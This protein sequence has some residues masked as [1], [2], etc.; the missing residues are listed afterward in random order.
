MDRGILETVRK[1][2]KV[3]CDEEKLGLD[4]NVHGIPDIIPDIRHSLVQFKVQLSKGA[5]SRLRLTCANIGFPIYSAIDECQCLSIHGN[6]P[7]LYFYAIC[8]C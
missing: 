8:C 2:S 1:I 3:V 6:C 5:T 7:V 4:H